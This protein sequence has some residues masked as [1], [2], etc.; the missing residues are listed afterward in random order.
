MKLAVVLLIL[1][2]PVT[3]YSQTPKAV[4][5]P[6]PANV[7]MP[8]GR[9]AELKALQDQATKL[10]QAM[11]EVQLRAAVL[12]NR[13]ALEAGLTVSQ[14]DNSDLVLDDKGNYQ[15]VPRKVPDGKGT[16]KN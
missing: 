6:K 11:K 16:P 13:A 10:E 2:L 15:W 7:K 8:E 9:S 1:L 3:A 14:L 5:P 12:I 4:V